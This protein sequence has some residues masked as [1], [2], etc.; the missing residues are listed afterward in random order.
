MGSDNSIV[1]ALER[2]WQSPC[3]YRFDCPIFHRTDVFQEQKAE[4]F[5]EALKDHIAITALL[6]Q[7]G[8]YVELAVRRIM[9]GGVIGFRAGD[10][11]FNAMFSGASVVGG[12]P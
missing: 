7:G 1:A 11:V 4:N 3:R 6:L 12:G 2:G 5:V 10:R 8:Q 9:P